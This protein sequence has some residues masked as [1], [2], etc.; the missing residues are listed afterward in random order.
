MPEKSLYQKY[1]SVIYIA[2]IVSLGFA[3][4]G[5]L[6]AVLAFWT[7]I[8]IPLTVLLVC[9]ILEKLGM[10]VLSLFGQ[11]FNGRSK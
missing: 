1:K 3:V 10:G 5:G 9:A 11:L 6:E 7:I 4:I 2:L 8:A